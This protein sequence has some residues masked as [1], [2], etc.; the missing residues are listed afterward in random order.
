[1][2]MED[3]DPGQLFT[4]D[5]FEEAARSRL[6]TSVYEYIAS[7]A[8]DDDTLHHNRRSL[9]RWRVLPRAMVDVTDLSTGSTV[10]GRPT[11]LPLLIAPSALQRLSH[12]DGEMAMAK[13]AAAADIPMI[14]SMNASTPLEEV[15]AS[16]AATWLQLYI[17]RDRQVTEDL[18]ARASSA[19]MDALCIT[20]DHAVLPWRVREL[21]R[22]LQVPPGVEF[23]HLPPDR[24]AGATETALTWDLVEWLRSTTPLRIVLKGILDP[25][26]AVLAAEHGVDA[27]IV[28]NHGGRQLA[29]SVSA[30]DMLPAIADRVGGRLEILAD[31]GVRS[32]MDL[33]R[34]LALGADAALIGR[35]AV[36]GLATAGE[37]GVTRV[38][39]LL[40]GEFT[41]ALGSTGCRTPAEIQRDRLV[42]ARYT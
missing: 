33:F 6:E 11:S 14:L 4:I 23:V 26:D 42:E 21:R 24:Q 15:A 19:G 13:A 18:V 35:P 34:A 39:Q 1:M 17:Y 8:G 37:A 5:E 16:G 10:L 32:G 27:I 22:P 25:A 7:G 38:L 30:W 29:G 9:E 36:W 3:V 40:A 28:S 12:P 41:S 31:G 2:V 20:V